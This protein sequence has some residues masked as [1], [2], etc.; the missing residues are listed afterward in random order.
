MKKDFFKD[1]VIVCCGTLSPEINR[2]KA[3]GFL[4]AKKIL[5]TKPGRHEVPQELESQLIDKIN[6]A[7][8]YSKKVI[9]I[10][11]GRY[12]YINMK[13]PEKNIDNIIKNLGKEITRI[14]ASHCIDVLAGKEE[15][16]TIAHEVVGSESVWW[17]TPGWILYRNS[18]FQ[19]WDKAMANENFP[20]HT[21]GAI[22]LDSIGFWD[23][24]SASHPEKILDFSDWMGIDIKPYTLSLDRFKKLLLEAIS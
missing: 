9:V 13:E 21:G 7:K 10:Y 5:F 17:L 15:R 22:L 19:D 12:C 16:E 1:H 6:K 24:Y 14:K 4:D 20:Q 23:E 11:G 8:E 18:V 2:L 3:D